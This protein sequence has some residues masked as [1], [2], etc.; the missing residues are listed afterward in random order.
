MNRFLVLALVAAGGSVQAASFGFNSVGTDTHGNPVGASVVFNVLDAHD[1][2]A[3]VRDTSGSILDL[4]QLI[5]GLKFSF[6]GT[7]LLLTGS[8][9]ERI[10]I[11]SDG[12]TTILGSGST[13]WGTSSSGG[14]WLLCATC[15]NGQGADIAG[16]NPS[17]SG[18]FLSGD[19][20]FKFTTDSSLPSDGTDPFA[21]VSFL[22]LNGAD[23]VLVPAPA[24]SGA[25]ADRKQGGAQGSGGS[26]GGNQGSAANGSGY[27]G[28]GGG[29]P[30]TPGTSGNSDTTGWSGSGPA[31]STGTGG[32]DFGNSGSGGAG[33]RD[34]G[35][36]GAIGG[37]S[38]PLSVS[39]RT[40]V[41][42]P[43]AATFPLA[44]V[45]LLGLAF[46]RRRS[47]A[48]R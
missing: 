4:E 15:G 30:F 2:T 34:L 32:T 36:S 24:G 23:L 12:R 46:C 27:A 21:N 44:G 29:G 31:G 19:V 13:N 26:S 22:F 6:S 18:T 5:E 45:A 7:G 14:A 41:A 39:P 10:M 17:I 8:D 48:T 11:G 40:F 47:R 20:T 43:E 9:G 16:S 38:D 35:T 28:S 1:F 42:V 25:T 37:N 33:S 3:T